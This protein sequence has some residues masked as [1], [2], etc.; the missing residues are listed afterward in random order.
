M[1]FFF[2]YFVEHFSIFKTIVFINHNEFYSLLNKESIYMTSHDYI[3][4][5]FLPRQEAERVIRG[6]IRKVRK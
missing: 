3:V 2:I 5:V 1:F 6:K 4:L